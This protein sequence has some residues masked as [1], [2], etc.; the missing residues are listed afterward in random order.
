MRG[1][2]AVEDILKNIP[3]PDPSTQM[4]IDA[5]DVIYYLPEYIFITEKDDIKVGVWDEKEKTW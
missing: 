5:V 4:Q 1:V 3:Y 2:H